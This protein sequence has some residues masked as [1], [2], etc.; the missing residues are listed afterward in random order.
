MAQNESEQ[1]LRLRRRIE[2]RLCDDPARRHG[3]GRAAA[4]WSAVYRSVTYRICDRDVFIV[5]SFAPPA[6]RF[7]RNQELDQTQS[8]DSMQT[9]PT[10]IPPTPDSVTDL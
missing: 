1:S 2:N 10:P 7:L 9:L 4:A 6:S 3:S 5:C 8:T